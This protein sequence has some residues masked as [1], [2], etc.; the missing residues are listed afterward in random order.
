MNYEDYQNTYPD[1]KAN[2]GAE[3]ERVLLKKQIL[4][5]I[6]EEDGGAH[7]Q[8]ANILSRFP[9]L[10]DAFIKTQKRLRELDQEYLDSPGNSSEKAGSE[11]A[12]AE[13]KLRRRFS[14]VGMNPSGEIYEAKF[15]AKVS[16]HFGEKV[17]GFYPTGYFDALVLMDQ[18]IYDDLA[19][20]AKEIFLHQ[21]AIKFYLRANEILKQYVQSSLQGKDDDSTETAELLNLDERSLQYDSRAALCVVTLLDSHFPVETAQAL[22]EIIDGLQELVKLD[23]EVPAKLELRNE[24]LDALQTSLSRY[25]ALEQD[26]D[27]IARRATELLALI[28]STP[29]LTVEQISLQRSAL[30][31]ALVQKIRDAESRQSPPKAEDASSTNG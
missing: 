21:D 3:E 22:I 17:E 23:T 7:E 29:E 13:I 14:K 24:A 16:R 20:K 5:E 8:L 12:V 15:D 26:Q 25:A 6:G 1:S 4:E 11:R 31:K 27:E 19:S 10:A 2:V 18:D 28:E 9:N 30:S